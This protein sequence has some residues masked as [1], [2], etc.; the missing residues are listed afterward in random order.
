MASSQGRQV[1]LQLPTPFR[2]VVLH[3]VA[4]RDRW[5]V[6]APRVT[7]AYKETAVRCGWLVEGKHQLK[8]NR[9]CTK[10]VRFFDENAGLL[11]VPAVVKVEEEE[12]EEQCELVKGRQF[13]QR[14]AE[15]ERERE[16]EREKTY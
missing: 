14:D 12:E 11:Q 15:R 5:R 8:A 3:A 4:G 9:L 13:R 6:V 16:R 2:E 1:G 10:L 7:F